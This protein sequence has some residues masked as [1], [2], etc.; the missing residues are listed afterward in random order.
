MRKKRCQYHPN[1]LQTQQLSAG[2]SSKY[3]QFVAH[4]LRV[5]QML[6]AVNLAIYAPVIFTASHILF[7]MHE[8]PLRGQVRG[9]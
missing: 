6:F 8:D 7:L 3:L 1:E 9:L 4:S 2:A 5:G